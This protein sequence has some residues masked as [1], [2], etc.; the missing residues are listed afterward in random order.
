MG[1]LGAGSHACG[2]KHTRRAGSSP[3]GKDCCPLAS[4][5]PCHK[6]SVSW[7]R[8]GNCWCKWPR[9]ASPAAPDD[10]GVAGGRPAPWG[11]EAKRPLASAEGAKEQDP[12]RAWG[13]VV[14]EPWW[15]SARWGTRWEHKHQ[16]HSGFSWAQLG[17]SQPRGCGQVCSAIQ[18]LGPPALLPALRRWN[19]P[20][21]LPGI[22]SYMI[23]SQGSCAVICLINQ[24]ESRVGKLWTARRDRK[25][26]EKW[27]H[28]KVAWQLLSYKRRQS[29][30]WTEGLVHNSGRR[31]KRN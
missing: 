30:E 2:D 6:P 1:F 14:V 22:F 8:C 11:D 21:L 3:Q 16:P 13:N 27:H 5:A 28:R 15:P 4:L 26:E 25:S 17:R 19:L 31:I 7:R 29:L 20:C 18:E 10:V 24:A 9:S 23:V 12:P